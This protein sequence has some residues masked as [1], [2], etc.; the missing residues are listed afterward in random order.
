MSAIEGCQHVL[1]KEQGLTSTRA[2]QHLEDSRELLPLL[3]HRERSHHM[4][5]I[6]GRR[7]AMIPAT[8]CRL[9]QVH[10]NSRRSARPAR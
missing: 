1:L 2:T 5:A 6:S 4:G 8:C 7:V 10:R 9:S 3:P